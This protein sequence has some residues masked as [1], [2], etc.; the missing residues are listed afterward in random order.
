MF[1]LVIVTATFFK[2]EE[3]AY[4]RDVALPLTMETLKLAERHGLWA[5]VV[6]GSPD[7]EVPRALTRAGAEVIR[8]ETPGFGP[9]VRQA[10]AAGARTIKA[11]GSVHW[12]EPMKADLVRFHTELAEAAKEADAA[13]LVPRR[14][15]ATW[16]TYPQ[17]QVW[18]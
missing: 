13:I 3:S 7:P 10:V 16:P 11:E 12:Q 8:Q 5:I 1:D 6:D 14:G 15:N 17:E 9:A 2:P 4:D 18:Q